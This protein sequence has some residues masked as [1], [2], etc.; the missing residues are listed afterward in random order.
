[1]R[2]IAVAIPVTYFLQVCFEIANDNE[3]PEARCAPR[4]RRA[5][6]PVCPASRAHA[7]LCLCNCYCAQ[8]WLEWPFSWRKLVFGFAAHREWHYTG[9]K[10]QPARHVKWFVRSVGAP[11]SETLANLW[12]SFKA[13]VT[14]TEPPWL[15]EARGAAAEDAVCN[16]LG[17]RPRRR[18]STGGPWRRS[19][20]RGVV[21]G[22]DTEDMDAGSDDD[23]A[24]E[25]SSV[26]SGRALTRYKRA[27]A[28][29]GVLGTYACWA[30]FTWFIFAYGQAIYTLLGGDAQGEFARSWGISYA[31]NTA[32]EWRAVAETAAKSALFLLLLER[33]RLTR[34]ADWLEARRP[35]ARA[36][37]CSACAAAVLSF[38]P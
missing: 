7:L 16:A 23:A 21:S 36:A 20:S 34:P 26:R 6:T 28:A 11:V 12:L 3:A 22:D 35:C 30:V 17:S 25:S 10:G 19:S 37:P 27:V 33:L 18:S 32:T 14:R 5:P 1:V 4:M 15:I 29:A 13:F 8:S 2:S 9:P 24:S 31:L 38:S